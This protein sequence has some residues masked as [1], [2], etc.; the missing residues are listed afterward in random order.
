MAKK[1]KIT[2]R[3]SRIGRSDRQRAILD[4]LGL[5]RRGRSVV[6]EDTPAVRGMVQKLAF[7]IDVEE[8]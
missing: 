7:M 2:L 3:K 6:R 1:I 8:C 4:G 5:K